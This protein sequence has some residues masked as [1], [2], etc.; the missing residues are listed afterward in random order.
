MIGVGGEIGQRPL[1]A[2]LGDEARELAHDLRPC[3]QRRHVRTPR[4]ELALADERLGAVIDDDTQIGMPVGEGEDTRQ[5][6][7]PGERIE[8]QPVCRHRV[9]R[10][11]YVGAQQPVVV[12]DVL[13]HG[14]QADQQSV[15][16]ERVDL[17]CGVCGGEIDPPDDTRDRRFTRRDLEHEARLGDRGGRLDEDRALDP[18]ALAER[19]EILCAEIAVDRTLLGRKP[20]IVPAGQLPEMLMGVDAHAY[21]GVGASAASRPAD[22]RDCHSSGGSGRARA[23]HCSATSSGVTAPSTTELTAGWARE[24]WSAAS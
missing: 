24:N 20:A 16:R 15:A 5:V 19:L 7:R 23:A 2:C 8:H 21:P 1:R 12:G 4:I 18:V 13:Q 17:L 22:F 11:L 14:A 9:H 6:P 3:G 10:G